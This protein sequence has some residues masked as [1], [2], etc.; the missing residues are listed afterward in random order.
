VVGCGPGRRGSGVLGGWGDGDVE[1]EGAELAQ[2]G[3]DLAVAVGCAFVPVGSEVD[4]PGFGAGEQVPDDDEDGAGDGAFGPVPAQAA[5]PCAEER[6]GACGAVG[7]LGAVPLEVGVALA[8]AR[9]AVA[10]PGLA[11]DRG[12]SARVRWGSPIISVGRR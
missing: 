12:T 11:G 8:F 4:E 2:V 5:E 9:L 1:A 6:F 7:G 3:A 10:G